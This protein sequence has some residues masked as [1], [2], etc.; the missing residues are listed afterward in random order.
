M[1]PTQTSTTVKVLSPT[2]HLY[3]YVLRNAINERPETL[4]KRRNSFSDN[5]QKLA[6][7][8]TSS[9]GKIA[10]DFVKL[11]PIEQDLAHSGTVLD[12]THA[13]PECIKPNDDRLYLDT[14]IIRSRLAARRLNDTYLLRF[15]S[16]VPSIH[17]EQ[18][19][20]IFA[21]LGENIASLP[22]ELGQTVILAAIVPSSHYSP[23]DIPLITTEC[24][25]NYYGTPIAPD[26]LIVNEFLGSPFC[27]YAQ[28]VT[29][30]FDKY[31]VETIH[32]ACIF[33]Y[34]DQAV[35]QQADKVYPI[36]QDMLLSYHKI[37][38]F[39]SQSTI[40]KKILAEQY[41]AIE[42][43]SKEYPQRQWNSQS[44]KKLPQQSLEYY[45]NLSFLEDQAKTIE[46]N[47]KNYQ[48]CIRQIEEKTGQNVPDYFSKFEQ[49]SNFYLEQI[50]INIGFLSPGI[51]LYDK[52][53]LS[54]QTQ[55]SIDEA[56]YQNQRSEQQAQLGQ[57]LAGVGAAIGVGQIINPPIT[58]TISQF[59]DK[60]KNQPSLSS[61][62]LGAGLTIILSILAGYYISLIVYRW[63][64]KPKG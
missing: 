48:E 42:L 39:H 5:L 29:L 59:L 51:Q 26:K 8:L 46:V 55:V 28:P 17:Q 14:G 61:S 52:L 13:P 38:F 33:L 25:K 54:I 57:I 3:H 30:K 16:Y 22:L 7:R 60:G 50:K 47:L 35:E 4:E 34:K 10:S 64:I 36:L 63:F 32:L 6:T 21:N 1:N 15:T 62:W 53:M 2:L 44:Y 18:P 49:E 23:P 20:P 40:L 41:E 58:A 43:L 19:L 9:T 37:H 24:L 27:I 31:T 11:V 12:L 56:A 45:K